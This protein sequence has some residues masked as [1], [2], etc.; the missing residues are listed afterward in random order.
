[1]LDLKILKNLT[2]LYAEDEEDIQKINTKTFELYFGKVIAV[3]NGNEA[4]DI[5]NNQR[6]DVIAL[7]VLMPQKDGISVAKQIRKSDFKTPIFVLSSQLETNSLL[8]ALKVNLVGYII[9]P[10]DYENLQEILK[11]CLNHL[12]IHNLL[13]F[14]IE[15]DIVFNFCSRAIES[16]KEISLTKKE[17]LLLELLCQNSG[18]VLSKEFLEYEVF[19]EPK[20]NSLKHLVYSLRKKLDT[21]RIFNVK[22]LGYLLQ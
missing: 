7:D 5:Y 19:E 8:E 3:S 13:Q 2:L 21:K 20:E 10:M 11:K 18:K 15:K 14:E 22:E 4:L 16:E 6:V 9:K 17:L 1:M 12:E